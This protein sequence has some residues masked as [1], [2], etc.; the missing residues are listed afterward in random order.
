M[1]NQNFFVYLVIFSFI[2]FL[3]TPLI[4]IAGSADN[5]LW[6]GYQDD[7]QTDSG[8]GNNDPRESVGSVIY[9]IL[10]FLGIITVFLIIYGVIQ[11]AGPDGAEKSKT[12]II[13]GIV[14]LIIVLM[15]FA[16]SQFVINAL[17]NATGATG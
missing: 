2:F 15:A 11:G 3:T 13:A 5:M 17:Y 1:K 8:L 14:G 7:V 16:I 4:S 9:I 10:G 12:T 6:G